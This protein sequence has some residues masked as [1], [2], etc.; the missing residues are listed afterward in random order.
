MGH[1]RVRAGSTAQG[2]RVRSVVIPVH[3]LS[4]FP[5]IR[6]G[7]TTA[8]DRALNST[9]SGICDRANDRP[10]APIQVQANVGP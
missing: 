2:C 6:H 7:F 5:A 4:C 8:T 9:Q 1:R 10:T 3:N